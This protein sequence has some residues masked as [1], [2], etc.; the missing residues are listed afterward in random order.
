MRV[1]VITIRL[2]LYY[3]RVNC[4][5]FHAYLFDG[6]LWIPWR[7]RSVIRHAIQLDRLTKHPIENIAQS[8]HRM[9]PPPGWFDCGA[10][11]LILLSNASQSMMIKTLFVSQ[12]NTRNTIRRDEWYWYVLANEHIPSEYFSKLTSMHACKWWNF[13]LLN[14]TKRNHS[15][16]LNSLC[17]WNENW[18]VNGN[19]SAKFNDIIIIWIFACLVWC[20]E[21]SMKQNCRNKQKTVQYFRTKNNR[22][23][24][25]LSLWICNLL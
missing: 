2:R 11:D 5:H 22:L 13:C 10:F 18:Y 12:S 20:D 24:F 19:F 14:E 8:V 3:S 1:G 25:S 21:H 9:Y 23:I 17:I 7:R 15:I 16:V 6:I 4:T